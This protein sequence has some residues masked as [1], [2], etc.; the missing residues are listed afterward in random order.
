MAKEELRKLD[1]EQTTLYLHALAEA[2]FRL[3]GFIPIVTGAAL[4]FLSRAQDAE[5]LGQ[6]LALKEVVTPWE[7]SFLVR[8]L[9]EVYDSRDI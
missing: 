9:R 4:V 2:R 5:Q 1:Y 3:L 8:I 7:P 6:S